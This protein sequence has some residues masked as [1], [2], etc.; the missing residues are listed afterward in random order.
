MC[1]QIKKAIPNESLQN[2]SVKV[3]VKFLALSAVG[4][5]LY[6][7]GSYIN[8]K[9]VE[10]TGK[11]CI[12]IKPSID[13]IPPRGMSNFIFDRQLFLSPTRKSTNSEGETRCSMSDMPCKKALPIAKVDGSYWLPY[14]KQSHRW[15]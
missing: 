12:A 15:S 7:N 10:V 13:P 14:C 5:I 2:E 11:C 9:V 6:W 3:E 1:N 8:D 4:D